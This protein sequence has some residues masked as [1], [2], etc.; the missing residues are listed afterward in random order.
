VYICSF[1]ISE[2]KTTEL[3]VAVMKVLLQLVR[4]KS[5]PLDQ[6]GH[7]FLSLV[8]P[9]ALFVRRELQIDLGVSFDG[10]AIHRIGL[11][12]PLLHGIHGGL[13]EHRIAWRALE[14]THLRQCDET[15][16]FRTWIRASIECT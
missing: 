7:A 12:L 14:Y 6:R 9:Q 11:V 3:K 5:P 4:Q 1:L 15:G 2:T 16:S 8:W 13:A 10:F